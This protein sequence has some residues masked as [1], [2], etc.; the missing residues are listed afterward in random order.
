MAETFAGFDSQDIS[1]YFGVSPIAGKALTHVATGSPVDALPTTE[2][3]ALQRINPDRFKPGASSY[4]QGY[5]DIPFGLNHLFQ[6]E[7]GS[8]Y[9]GDFNIGLNSFNF[10]KFFDR[11]FTI[12]PQSFTPGNVARAAASGTLTVFTGGLV[13]DV[14]I[15]NT[16]VI[17]TSQHDASVLGSV[18]TGANS[19]GTV[20]S[21]D[22]KNKESLINKIGRLFGGAVS[23][24]ATGKAATGY[25]SNTNALPSGVQGPVQ[26]LSFTQQAGN[27]LS[28]GVSLASQGYSGGQISQVVV[29]IL[30][31]KLGGALLALLS[32]DLQGAIKIISSNPSQPI[33]QNPSNSLLYGPSGG[34]GGG[35]GLGLGGQNTGQTTSNSLVYLLIA[36]ILILG[37]VYLLR[38]K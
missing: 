9:G 35:S 8:H 3:Q 22:P 32:G 23:T 13:T 29:G 26:E 2:L 5:G 28:G 37:G 6:H 38:R 1:Q 27:T 24:I 25:L 36:G 31:N 10:G 19:F 18:Y 16:P 34:G 17:A 11:L 4:D 33:V 30:G 7:K 20:Q 21:G 15:A 12:R 14:S